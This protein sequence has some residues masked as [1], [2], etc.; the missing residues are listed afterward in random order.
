MVA[1]ND[2]S[3][4]DP[5]PEPEDIEFI[6][7]EQDNEHT[8]PDVSVEPSVI[9]KQEIVP[10]PLEPASMGSASASSQ[11]PSEAPVRES[12]LN[13]PE[14][15]KQSEGMSL[16]QVLFSRAYSICRGEKTILAKGP[17]TLC[18]KLISA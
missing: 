18:W 7:E 2:P 5:E 16:V 8:K 9:T 3:F 12:A 4:R 6:D 1:I 17:A 10:V 14:P 15:E 13:P 11:V